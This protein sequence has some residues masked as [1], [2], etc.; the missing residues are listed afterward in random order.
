[1]KS[2][3][4]LIALVGMLLSISI[5]CGILLFSQQKSYNFDNGH[6]RFYIDP[7][8][9]LTEDYSYGFT[10]SLIF[11][12]VDDQNPSGILTLQIYSNK[13]EID[14]KSALELFEEDEISFEAT[15]FKEI[16]TS[17]TAGG[18][19]DLIS[20]GDPMKQLYLVRETDKYITVLRVLTTPE[21]FSQLERYFLHLPVSIDAYGL[22]VLTP[23]EQIHEYFE[24]NS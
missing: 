10:T 9:N 1:M 23:G 8:L 22:G 20:Q 17:D 13:S 6:V 7:H 15:E 2:K 14:A 3:Q 16:S 4:R 24:K 11:S 5:V 12:L 19:W 21:L 18:Q